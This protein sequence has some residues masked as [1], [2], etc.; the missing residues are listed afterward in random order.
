MADRE[1][2]IPPPPSKVAKRSPWA[3]ATQNLVAMGATTLLAYTGHIS[4]NTAAV[5]IMATLGVISLGAFTGKK[6]GGTGIGGIGI[7]TLAAKP[8]LLLSG[9]LLRHPL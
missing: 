6:G 2:S 5:M 9:I 8:A 4:G 7:L 3:A 1:T